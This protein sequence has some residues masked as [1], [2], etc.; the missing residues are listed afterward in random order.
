MF[1]RIRALFADDAD[2]KTESLDE[3]EAVATLLAHAAYADGVFQDAE[4]AMVLQL[5]AKRYELAPAAANDLLQKAETRVKESVE[6]YGVTKTAKDIFSHGE[7]LDLMEMIWE[8]VLADG[9]VDEFEANLM[10]RLAGL[11]YVTD[12]E[13]GAARKRAAARVQAAG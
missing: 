11:M 5:L 9:V 8:V 12:Q 1:D 7:R 3:S 10:R 13:S 2:D 4:H 6:L